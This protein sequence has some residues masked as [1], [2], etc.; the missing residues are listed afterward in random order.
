MPNQVR[1][2]VGVT[3]AKGA[4][5][6]LDRLRDKFTALQKQGAKG[7]AIGAGV[8]ATSAGLSLIGNALGGVTGFMAH[9]VQAASDLNETLSK[10]KVVFGSAAAGVE[11]FGESAAT[12]LGLSKQAAIE[13][14]ASFGNVF[15]GLGFAADQSAKMSENLVKL[16]GDLASFNNIDPTE[17]LEKL[18]SGL[19]GEAEPL[20]SV[21]VFLTEAQV[22]AKAMQLGLADAH[23][24][25]SEGAKILARYHLILDQTGTAQGDFARTSDGLANSQRIANAEY[26][27]AQAILGQKLLPVQLAFTRALIGSTDAFDGLLAGVHDLTH[28]TDKEDP[29]VWSAKIVGQFGKL[30]VEGGNAARM[31]EHVG[32]EAAT[33]GGPVQNFGGAIA[34]AGAALADISRPGEF[35]ATLIHKI[36]SAAYAADLGVQTLADTI[37]H[38]LFGKAITAGNEAQL[39]DNIKDLE[40]QRSETHKGSLKWL[41]LTG[42]LAEARQA[43]FDLH[44]EMAKEKGPDAV[45]AFLRETR[46]GL[47]KTDKKTRAL[48]DS[49][50]A[51]YAQLDKAPGALAAAGAALGSLVVPHHAPLP[52]RAAGGPV[53]AGQGYLVNEN[54]PNS[55]VFVPSQNGTIVPHGGMGGLTV[56]VNVTAPRSGSA[57]DFGQAVGDAV[58][59]VLREQ[60]ARLPVGATA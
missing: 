30:N 21:G 5:S 1:V 3:G 39:K 17:A 8:A 57:R 59:S 4:S 48:I 2:G 41:E 51:L 33:S 35:A 12:S 29:A 27:N 50:I 23:G 25:L 18:R 16:A 38:D 58:A 37:E 53:S 19:A 34:E 7:L 54:T 42:Q 52:H 26:E 45:L 49:L 60:S 28:L 36:G 13:A 6:E 55:E 10:S 43:L 11:A 56:N 9:S 20:R 32:R 44:F 40:K 14:A 46:A 15:K 24:E 22:K 31:L 47:A